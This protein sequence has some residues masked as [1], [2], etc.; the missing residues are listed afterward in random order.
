MRALVVGIDGYIGWPLSLRLAT[1][2]FEVFGI[3]DLS[4]REY[5]KVVKCSSITP[6][7]PLQNRIASTNYHA[8]VW[9]SCARRE[10]VLL[11]IIR[12]YKPDVAY[13]LTRPD[14]EG[15]SIIRR[16]LAET[17]ALLV[18]CS[19]PLDKAHEGGPEIFVQV[20]SVFGLNHSDISHNR[21]WTTRLDWDP[22]SSALHRALVCS[23]AGDAGPVTDDLKDHLPL[24]CLVN[25]L[26]KLPWLRSKGSRSIRVQGVSFPGGLSWALR[27][28]TNWGVV[29]QVLLTEGNKANSGAPEGYECV[30]PRFDADRELRSLIAEMIRHR[31]RI[32]AFPIGEGV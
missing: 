5:S 20:G 27:C 1:A 17:E 24:E 28:L 21:A 15:L 13:Y 4:R 9:K 10:E 25:E 8:Q 22:S 3:D 29:S 6:I 31:S 11:P 7:A 2:G 23:I 18:Q 30:Q 14:D 19:A 12:E 26:V 32:A 16:A